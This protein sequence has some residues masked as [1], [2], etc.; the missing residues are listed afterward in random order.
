M[1]LGSHVRQ[2]DP[3]NDVFKWLLEAPCHSWSV[4][5]TPLRL[6]ILSN[7]TTTS[8]CIALMY[9]HVWMTGRLGLYSTNGKTNGHGRLLKIRGA[10]Q[11][12]RTFITLF[13]HF[14]AYAPCGALNAHVLCGEAKMNGMTRVG[15]RSGGWRREAL[16]T[17]LLGVYFAS[18]IASTFISSQ[19]GMQGALQV[20]TG[21][22]AAGTCPSIEYHFRDRCTA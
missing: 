6:Q 16:G 1:P 11:V 19:T 3:F 21:P 22:T 18:R 15:R 9:I 20:L 4:L 8:F 5:S 14:P 13:L 7:S 2:P 17:G 10:V 12:S